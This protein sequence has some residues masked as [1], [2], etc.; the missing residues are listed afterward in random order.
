MLVL[1]VDPSYIGC[2]WAFYSGG[3]VDPSH[4]GQVKG[5]LTRQANFWRELFSRNIR[6]EPI[7]AIEDQYFAQN[8]PTIKKLILARGVCEGAYR[9]VF[10]RDPIVVPPRT[11]Q[12][13]VRVPFGAKRKVCEAYAKEFAHRVAGHTLPNQHIREALCIAV[14]TFDRLRSGDLAGERSGAGSTDQR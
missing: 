10:A 13:A 8:F 3:R 4:Y 12:S 7:L 14:T 11:W 9:A 1:G 5:D 6:A 2:Y